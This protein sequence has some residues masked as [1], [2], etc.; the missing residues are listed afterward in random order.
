MLDVLTITL[1]PAIDQTVWIDDFQADSVNRI[2]KLQNDPGG[3]GINVAAYLAASGLKVGAT[4]F[5]G[6]KNP[7]LFEKLFKKYKIK[8]SFIYLK[9]QTRTNLKIIDEKNQTVTDINQSGF[10]IDVKDLQR[11]EKALFS[12]P[13]A[14]WYVFSGSLPQGIKSDIYEQWIEKAHILG[15]KIALDAS[16][17]ALIDAVKAK[18]ELI[19]P[20]HHELSQ[21]F[22]K[23]IKEQDEF[24]VYAKKL[25]ATGI[26]SVCISMGEKGALL[27]NYKEVFYSNPV[28]V[29]VSTTVG[30]GDAML[31]GLI[32]GNI[33]GFST[34]KSLK[35]A[36]AYS[37]SAIQTV[38][39]YLE[40]KKKLKKYYEQI[41]LE[42][43]I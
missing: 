12:T 11:L 18:P 27:V 29:N 7:L 8:D 34:Q 25:I 41:D 10:Q 17:E 32:L 21:L 9:E 4:G 2:K 3:K 15:I 6:K 38:G 14:K 31:S 13:K 33:K 39:P 1:N 35:I 40:S 24:I 22:S 5:L 19:K 30:A 16:G 23:E 43:L 20:N 37:L 28:K 36:T 26:N 42:N